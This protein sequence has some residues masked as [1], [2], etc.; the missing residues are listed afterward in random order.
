MRHLRSIL[1]ALVLA[2]VVW[3]LCGVG[4]TRETTGWAL[5]PLLL[6][7]AAYAILLFA[8]IS[9]AGPALSGLVL[10]G[11]GGWALVAPDSY[12]SVWPAGGLDLSRPGYALA[13][14]LAL[15]LVSTA[16]SARRWAG[17]EPPQIPII[18]TIGRAR[19]R[20]AAPGT[21][22]ASAPTAAFR[23]EVD[24]DG[25]EPT[26]IFPAQ[27]T[28]FSEQPTEPFTEPFTEPVRTADEPVTQAQ[29][30]EP[31]TD[32]TEPVTEPV[33]EARPTEPI[34][35]D[36]EPTTTVVDTGEPTRIF[37][38]H[39]DGVAEALSPEEITA[40]HQVT[41][42]IAEPEAGE[43]TVAEEERTV[44]T[45][46]DEDGEKTQVIRLP[47]G[48][49]AGTGPTRD[50]GAGPTRDFRGGG[51]TYLDGP[52][53]QTQVIYLLEPTNAEHAAQQ[54]AKARAAEQEARD[55]TAQ[56]KARQAFKDRA[57]L[58]RARQAFDER[59]A[60]EAR[61]VGEKTRIIK[62]P[63]RDEKPPA[64]DRTTRLP[65]TEDRTT[66]L[67]VAEDKTTRLPVAEEE[68]TTLLVTPPDD[69]EKT[70]A[71]HMPDGNGDDT[72][73]LRHATVMAEPVEGMAGE[74]KSRSI[75]DQ[76]RP[77]PAADPTTRL[78]PPQREP[79]DTQ[80]EP[81]DTQRQPEET[82]RQPGETQRRP[83]ETQRPRSLMD[84]ERP[85]DE[86]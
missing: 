62:L 28:A 1:Y 50:V 48:R 20:A 65:V 7:G 82:R 16:L 52:G 11:A 9:P 35:A 6:G 84:L 31:I 80:R 69:G 59:A 79:E 55:L 38:T 70:T 72:T 57:A 15:P 71:L 10:L 76:E 66:R 22:L 34:A 74:S 60:A 17:Y 29:P 14:I 51:K 12:G 86:S 25:D 42:P 5:A 75:V 2:P 83:E 45:A 30:T 8:P 33:T 56:E 3:V 54:A 4:L 81:E 49:E 43:P 24:D 13:A 47:R 67:P 23:P 78:I 21:P 41:E 77:D 46:T 64:E 58:E 37:V 68:K 26:T 27:R 53:E 36:D 44:A 73:L 63:V 32:S 18:G 39:P 19:G 40:S 61:S 85:A